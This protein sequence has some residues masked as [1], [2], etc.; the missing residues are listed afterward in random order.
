MNTTNIQPTI[1]SGAKDE[2][3]LYW[4]NTHRNA[5]NQTFLGKSLSLTRTY[6][7]VVK[8][9]FC[10]HTHMDHFRLVSSVN[11]APRV[12][13]H[14][15]PALSPQFNNNPAFQVLKYDTESFVVQDFS[16]YYFHYASSSWRFEYDFTQTYGKTPCN[17]NNTGIVYGM[18]R[19]NAGARQSF[20]K[21]YDVSS[22][23]SAPV[24]PTNWKAYRCG[25]AELTGT[26]FSAC[27]GSAQGNTP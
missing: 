18:L 1:D 23:K 6:G 4:D 15:I 21:L 13:I 5:T 14:I 2:V 17:A 25:I 12:Y 27:Y 3:G 16:T 9:V 26:D 11:D 22:V 10:G 19:N 7:A 24:T 20:M 8:A